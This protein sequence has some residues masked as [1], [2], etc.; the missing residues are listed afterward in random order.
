MTKRS[1]S[2]LPRVS[3][4]LAALL[5]CLCL[6][7]CGDAGGG[8]VDKGPSEQGGQ[9]DKGG[10]EPAAFAGAV[11]NAD[12]IAVIRRNGGRSLRQE[13]RSVMEGRHRLH[14]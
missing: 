6:S 10:F 14:V 4:F 9:L 5:I 13:V 1:Q 11:F 3:A 12:S 2:I 8:F 7:G